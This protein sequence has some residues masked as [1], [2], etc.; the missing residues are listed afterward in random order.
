MIQIFKLNIKDVGQPRVDISHSNVKPEGGKCIHI[1]KISYKMNI[2]NIFFSEN[3]PCR[4][5]L[6]LL[7]DLLN[8]CFI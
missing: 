8:I 2:F 3:C 6:S 5:F 4:T 7:V 1:S